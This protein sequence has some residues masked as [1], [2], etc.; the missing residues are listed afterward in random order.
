MHLREHMGNLDPEHLKA[1][2]NEQAQISTKR[3]RIATD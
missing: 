1:G 3:H 2:S